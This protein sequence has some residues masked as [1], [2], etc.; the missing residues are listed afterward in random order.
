MTLEAF[1]FEGIYRSDLQSLWALLVAPIAFLAWR[2][3]RPT[4][5][6]RAIV[7]EASRFV[8]VLTL[9]F[10]VLTMVDPISTGP[11]AHLESLEGTPL[12]LL[13]MFF[14]VLLGDFRVL[15]LTIGVARPE[16]T[17]PRRLG[18]AAAVT[19]VVPLITGLIYGPLSLLVADLHGQWLWMIYEAGFAM[20]CIALSRRWLS[21]SLEGA[22]NAV[23]KQDFLRD[24]F[25]YSAAYYVLW[26]FADALIVV[27]DLDLGWA[28]RIV[29][30]QLYY[31]L[32]VP[33]VYSRFYSVPATPWPDVPA[34][35]TG[36]AA[37]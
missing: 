6:T 15:L 25:A 34:S 20:L 8:S 24:V 7:P 36:N 31:A 1:S 27:G 21:R 32:W 12:P 4:D 19:L 17:L 28:I 30:N 10:A 2:A 11:I 5:P 23:A 3:A 16:Q 13:I 37:R 35:R 22:A 14:F 18:W 29:P 9:C 33:F 26:L